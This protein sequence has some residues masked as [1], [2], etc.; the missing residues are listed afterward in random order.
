MNTI[1][2]GRNG[3]LRNPD[4]T[5]MLREKTCSVD[6]S[7]LPWVCCTEEETSVAE[8]CLSCGKVQDIKGSIYVPLCSDCD[9]ARPGDYPWMVRLLFRGAGFVKIDA[10]LN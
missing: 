6:N 4:A 2:P 9:D 8:R 1:S 5:R 10:D 3:G 7:N